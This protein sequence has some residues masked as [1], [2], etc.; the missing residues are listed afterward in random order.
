MGGS[1]EGAHL[2][3]DVAVRHRHALMVAHGCRPRPNPQFDKKAY[4]RRNIVERAISWLKENRRLAT[5]FE[6][7][8]TNFLGMAK[9][10]MFQLCLRL[11]GSLDRA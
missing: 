6:K 4:R 1:E 5:G 11:L 10:A 7:L 9:L 3:L 8:V 2:L